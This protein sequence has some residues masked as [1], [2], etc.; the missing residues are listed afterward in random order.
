MEKYNFF[1]IIRTAS[2]EAYGIRVGD[3]V[4]GQALNDGNI[5]FIEYITTNGSD[6]NFASSFIS[7]AI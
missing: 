4:I 6:A 3:D 1:R 5:I 2:S 7:V